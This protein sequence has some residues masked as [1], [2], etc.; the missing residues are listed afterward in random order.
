MFRCNLKGLSYAEKQLSLSKF[1]MPKFKSCMYLILIYIFAT[2]YVV[3]ISI[4]FGPFI[5]YGD[6][7]LTPGDGV[8]DMSTLTN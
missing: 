7:H 3:G 2:Y 6:M 1:M 8:V 5:N 4:S